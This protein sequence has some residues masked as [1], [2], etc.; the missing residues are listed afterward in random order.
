MKKLCTAALA[1]TAAAALLCQT[2]APAVYAETNNN[3]IYDYNYAADGTVLMETGDRILV[4][5]NKNDGRKASLKHNADNWCVIVDSDTGA[6]SPV[7]L[8]DL[9]YSA[10][11]ADGENDLKLINNKKLQKQSGIYPY[12]TMDGMSVDCENGGAVLITIEGLSAGKHTLTT[13]HSCPENT[14]VGTLRVSVNGEVTAEGIPCPTRVTNE[15]DAGIAYSEFTA[16]EGQAVTLLI[17]PEN[18]ETDNAWINA[19]EIDGGDPVNGVSRNV[20]EHGDS[21]HNAEEGLSWTAAAD[22][23]RHD[24]YLGT[25]FE[26]VENADKGYREY[27]GS[28]E[29]TSFPLDESLS[30]LPVYYWRVDTVDSSGNVIKG[31][32]NAFQLTRLSFPTAEGYGRFARGGRGG[33]VVHVTSLEDKEED[34]ETEGTLRWALCSEKWLTEDWKGVPRIVVFDVG[35]VITLDDDI[36]I[37]DNGGNVY[38]A[39]QTAPGDGITLTKYSFSAVG[40]SDVII[41]DIRVRPGDYDM[42]HTTGISIGSCDHTIVDH[43]SVSWATEEGFSS[44]SAKNVT[45]QWNIIAESIDLYGSGCFGGTDEVDSFA[46]SV[47]GYTGSYHHNLLTNCSGRNWSLAGAMEYDAVHYGGRADIRNNVVYNWYDRTT[48]GVMNELNFVNNYYKAGPASETDIHIIQSDG[49]ELATGNPQKTY[50]DGNVMVDTDGTV[51]LSADENAW[52]A[53]KSVCRGMGGATVEDVRSDEPFFESFVNTETAEEAYES[54]L[55]GAGAGVR[56][57]AGRD[58]IDSRYIDEVTNGTVTYTGTKTEIPGVPNS[59]EEI[60]G[61]PAEETFEHSTDGMTNA[62]NDTDRDGMPN[63]WE[64]ERG[65]DPDDPSDGSIVSLSAEDYTNIEIYLGELMGETFVYAEEKEAVMGDVNADSKFSAADYVM[66]QKRLINEGTLKDWDAAD[67]C[68]DGMINIFDLMLMK[69][70]LAEAVL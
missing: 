8:S 54:V 49:D 2:A 16:E 4:D 17:E 23:A 14:Q 68:A 50:V 35:G 15:W 32:V 38:V 1:F 55:A 51:L 64:E 30:S 31:S 62:E 59:M 28:T 27:Q 56:T 18:P 40:S 20:P 25:D 66:L 47:G 52:D 36:C 69:K 22:A 42:L 39:G 41:R 19:F 53:G 6:A 45:F 67:I 46:A 70:L 63:V 9:T 10:D 58:Y 12:L 21:H 5:I 24:V 44:R 57:S 48:D 37:P 11:S 26:R 34:T 43:C 13:W 7:T 65:L 60:G 3:G 29:E 61:F 33:V